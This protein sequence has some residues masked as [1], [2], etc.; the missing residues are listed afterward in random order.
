MKAA[1]F[2]ELLT[3]VR[4]AGE[5]RRGRGKP[6]RTTAFKPADVRALRSDLGQSQVEFALMIGVSVATLRN[7]EQGRRTPDGPALDLLRVA[8]RDPQAVV[9]A[10]HGA[11]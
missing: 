8:A 2:E 11:R 6:S 3:S 10:L 5:I 4:Q 9:A 1:A 7:W